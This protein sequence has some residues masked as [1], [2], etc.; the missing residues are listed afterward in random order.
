MFQLISFI[1]DFFLFDYLTFFGYKLFFNGTVVRI[2]LFLN[3][4]N[5]SIIFLKSFC[6]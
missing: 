3:Y 5:S 2:Y 4:S 1:N 6:I